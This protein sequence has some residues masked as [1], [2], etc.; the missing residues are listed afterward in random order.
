M[1]IKNAGTKNKE[2]KK[3]VST[4]I[5]FLTNQVSY[6]ICYTA[7]ASENYQAWFFD[8]HLVNAYILKKVL[9]PNINDGYHMV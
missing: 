7:L 1:N 2:I 5:Y 6:T 3:D 4:L 9:N 8:Q